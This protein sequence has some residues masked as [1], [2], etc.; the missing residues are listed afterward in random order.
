M[1]FDMFT[2]SLQQT[3]QIHPPRSTSI[4]ER[5]LS[6]FS[7]KILF[8]FLQPN[9]RRENVCLTQTKQTR[10]LKLKKQNVYYYRRDESIHTQSKF[11]EQLHEVF[12]TVAS[13]NSP[14][15]STE[16]HLHFRRNCGHYP[17]LNLC[18]AVR[19][20]YRRGL[21]LYKCCQLTV[22]P[23]IMRLNKTEETDT[24]PFSGFGSTRE[25]SELRA[26]LTE[27]AT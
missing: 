2:H 14:F 12:R 1:V 9:K 18:F 24:N 11:S 15:I 23:G 17:V 21:T 26:H 22:I 3:Y 27:R 7:M 16:Q 25:E 19:T 4:E 10:K 5:H 13:R 8:Q 20:I 6:I